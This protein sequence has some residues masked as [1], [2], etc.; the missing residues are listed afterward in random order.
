MTSIATPLTAE[1]K[2][3]NLVEASAGTGKTHNIGALFVRLIVEAGLGVDQILVVTF[4]E[5]ATADLRDRIRKRLRQALAMLDGDD[6]EDEQ[7]ATILARAPGEARK[8]LLSALRCFDEAPISTI[9]GF[10]RRMLLQNAFESGVLFDTELVPD[11]GLLVDQVI[12]DFWAAR[13]YRAA[14]AFVGHLDKMKVKPSTLLRLVHEIV[15]RPDRRILPERMEPFGPR[16]ALEAAHRSLRRI[17]QRDEVEIRELLATSRGVNRGRYN[18]TRLPEWLGQVEDYLALDKPWEVEIPVGVEKLSRSGLAEKP[19]KGHPPPEHL[20]FDACEEMCSVLDGQLLAFKRELAEYARTE[21][22]RRKAERGQQSFDDLLHHLAAALEGRAGQRLAA[23]IRSQYKAALIDEFQDTD[24]VQYRIFKRI[25]QGASGEQPP[26]FLI[27][28]PKQS[29]YAFRGADIFAYLEAIVDAGERRMDLAF[30]W[31]SDPALIRGVNRI[32]GRSVD[33]FLID[34]IGFLPVEPCPNARDRLEVDGGRPPAIGFRFLPRDELAGAQ[35]V[36]DKGVANE[37]LP[38]LVAADI[39]NLLGSGATIDGISISAGDVAVLVRE[40]RQAAEMQDALREREIPSVLVSV[41]SVFDTKEAGDLA[42]LLRAVAEPGRP[43]KL[44]TAMGTDLLGLTGNRICELQKDEDGWERWVQQF[45]AWRDRWEQA[46]PIQ[47]LREVFAWRPDPG[48]LPIQARLLGLADGERRMTNFLHLAELLHARAVSSHLGISGLLRWFDDQRR[49]GVEPDAAQLRLE[50][51]EQ[52]VKLVT[53]HKS[54]GL[55]YPVVYCPYLWDGKIRDEDPVGFHDPGDSYLPKLDLGSDLLAEHQARAR[56]EAMAESLR[57]AYVAL[58]RA[59]HMC[60]IA[61]GGF[62]GMGTSPLGY[63]LHHPGG[64]RDPSKFGVQVEAK[65]DDELLAD[66]H[67]LAAGAAGAIQTGEFAAAPK[68]TYH[69]SVDLDR[70]LTFEEARR[71]L[72]IMWHTSSFSS[73]VSSG[74]ALTPDES[75]GRDRD[76]VEEGPPQPLALVDDSA[77]VPLAA[78]A[79]GARTGN[80]LHDLFE[81]LDFTAADG[82]DFR[83]LVSDRLTAYGFETSAWEETLC[84]AIR[85]VLETPLDPQVPD[86]CLG[87]L[88]PQ[89]RLDELEFLFP[90]DHHQKDGTALA[91]IFAAHGSRAVPN[92]YPQRLK[93]LEFKQVVGFMRGFV[94]LVFEHQGRWYVVDYK[95]NHLGDTF[96]GYAPARLALAMAE[97]HY[98]LQY[99]IYCV[100]LHRYLDYRLQDYDFERHFGGVYYLFLRGMSPATGSQRAV[101]RDRPSADMIAGLSDLLGGG[102][103]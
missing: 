63:L 28:D 12:A 36:I 23:R 96:A 65:T 81:H 58:T 64:E 62:K 102:G 27:G 34:R 72:P 13:V 25:F 2:G 90:T 30:N 61:W 1:L 71:R 75:E 66:L 59:R 22:R 93:R 16:A 9:H 29:I 84:A 42:H 3:V 38:G 46:G 7:L 24:H 20:F 80:M 100:A 52:A 83:D 48:G 85:A 69:P 6:V 73:L 101:F 95:S 56:Y 86:L 87:R 74:A 91:E 11:Q 31:R 37:L 40:N 4:T 17:W 89:R 88:P 14:P 103:S 8:R 18:K 92:D 39:H 15:S 51:D 41:A 70:E 55:Q 94:D 78:L 47:M 49:S 67:D 77:E 60:V 50:S 57:L 99:H 5:A 79:R 82:G 97:H 32:F 54:K 76:L 43:D 44:R 33:P 53:I 68:G 35:G 21:M 10:C 19:A 26:L 98:F 45:R